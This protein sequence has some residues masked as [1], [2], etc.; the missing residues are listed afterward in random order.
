LETAV[1]NTLSPGDRVLGV[2]AGAFGNRFRTIAKT[3]GADVVPLDFEWGRAAEPERIREAV[4][5]NKDLRAVLLTHNETSTGV[6]HPLEEICE[7]VRKESDALVLVDAVSG[8]GGIALPLDSWGI[9]VVITGSQ[10]A[11]GVPPGV[12]MIGFGTRAWEAYEKAT[13]PRFYFDLGRYRD[14]AIK[15]Q[16]PYT[17]ALSVFYGLEKALA[18]ML[19]EGPA[20]VYRR[21]ERVAM[22]TRQGIESMGL[23]LFADK[24]FLSN[25]VTA[26]WVPD[27]VDGKDLT[28]VLREKYDTV[29]GGGQAHMAGR[30]LRIGHLGWVE[31]G[32]IEDAL[33][34][35]N[36]ALSDLGYV[37]RSL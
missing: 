15:G 23:S 9:D 30:I 19:E 37:G 1:V 21:H 24:R 6:T 14:A 31:E 13:M 5:S 33:R 18:L 3:Y 20:S 32:D 29:V 22:K 35:L 36:S 17:P 27:G 10:K 11:W 26:V 34:A 7:T 28:R 2:S 16:H 12:A 4:R 25:T 8:L